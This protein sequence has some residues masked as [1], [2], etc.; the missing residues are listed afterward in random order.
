MKSSPRKKEI[1]RTPLNLT[2]SSPV[3]GRPC[4]WWAPLKNGKVIVEVWPVG[5]QEDLRRNRHRKIKSWGF[6]DVHKFVAYYK[7][8]P[9]IR[10]TVM[11]KPSSQRVGKPLANGSIEWR[12]DISMAQLDKSKLLYKYITT[13]YELTTGRP[14]NDLEAQR[15]IELKNTGKT[16][17]EVSTIIKREFGFDSDRDSIRKLADNYKKRNPGEITS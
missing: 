10:C 9:Q 16:W 11:F 12:G 6:G 5:H 1:K 14:P 8:A 17:P 2:F 15:A 7:D 4:V 3:K 13:F